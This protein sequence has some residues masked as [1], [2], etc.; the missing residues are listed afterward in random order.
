MRAWACMPAL[1]SRMRACLR[2]SRGPRLPAL[3]LTQ[4]TRTRTGAGSA[5]CTPPRAL[6]ALNTHT[7]THTH[8]PPAHAVLDEGAS[9]KHEPREGRGCMGWRGAGGGSVRV[10]GHGAR[11]LLQLLLLLLLP[12]CRGRGAVGAE[13]GLFLLAWSKD[14]QG[15]HARK[16]GGPAPTPSAVGNGTS[17]RARGTQKHLLVRVGL[18]AG[19]AAKNAAKHTLPL[20]PTAI[21]PVQVCRGQNTR[22][23]SKPRPSSLLLLS[24]FL[25]L[26][27]RQRTDMYSTCTSILRGSAMPTEAAARWQAVFPAGLGQETLAKSLSRVN[28]MMLSAVH[29]LA[30]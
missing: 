19:C 17:A 4:P 10:S 30:L 22:C 12:V 3:P 24:R 29:P 5:P 7:H 13:G 9:T 23:P 1:L 15:S 11:G 21:P 8:N 2:C 20:C 18:L 28:K 6:T 27:G 16:R 14:A 26:E 25:N